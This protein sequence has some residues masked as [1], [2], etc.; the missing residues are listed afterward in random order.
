M[1]LFLLPTSQQQTS[2]A[3]FV[4]P[5]DSGSLQKPCG[6]EFPASPTAAQDFAHMR[7]GSEEV[8]CPALPALSFSKALGGGLCKK[9]SPAV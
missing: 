4:S 3:S 2:F 1:Q 6:L 8:V 5:R 9:D 7:E